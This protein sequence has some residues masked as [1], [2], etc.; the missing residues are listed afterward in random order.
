MT[1]KQKQNRIAK[2]LL[3][4]LLFCSCTKEQIISKDGVDS[5][6][7]EDKFLFSPQEG[8]DDVY[9]RSVSSSSGSNFLHNNFAVFCAMTKRANYIG[10]LHTFNWMYKAK[11]ERVAT[12]WQYTETNGD[13]YFEYWKPDGLHSFFAFAPYQALESDNV[14]GSHNVTLT[15]GASNIKLTP[16]LENFRVPTNSIKSGY[17]LMYASAINL[18]GN[19]YPIDGFQGDDYPLDGKVNLV[20]YHAL[21][22]VSFDFKLHSNLAEYLDSNPDDYIKVNKISFSNVK[23][24]GTLSFQSDGSARWPLTSGNTNI[25]W[26]GNGEGIFTDAKWS[27]MLGASKTVSAIPLSVDSQTY[28]A[29]MIPQVFSED[30]AL[31]L[32]YYRESRK[33]GVNKGVFTSTRLLKDFTN[34]PSE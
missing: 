21:S 24:S 2:I 12:E 19:N 32:E 7:N 28:I 20:F 15:P 33:G 29:T 3:A 4:S 25:T 14:D 9:S 17:D 1:S 27:H 8:W 34:L 16:S 31:V 10:A 30:A 26:G 18:E 22:Q 11:I 6:P 13:Y 5:I 23:N